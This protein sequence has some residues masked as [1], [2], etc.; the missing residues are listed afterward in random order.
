MQG[1]I[2]HEIRVNTE[3]LRRHFESSSTHCDEPSV[4]DLAHSLRLFADMNRSG[5]LQEAGGCAR[6]DVSLETVD[7]PPDVKSSIPEE[8]DY[9]LLHMSRKITVTPATPVPILS[10]SRGAFDNFNKSEFSFRANFGSRPSI[11]VGGL[12]LTFGQR[13]EDASQVSIS[14]GELSRRSL[15][16]W[17]W[18]D[19]PLIT[20]R[21]HDNEGARHCLQMSRVDVIR[22]VANHLGGSHPA[23]EAPRCRIDKALRVVL[24]YRQ[25]GL[26]LPFFALMEVASG[27]LEKLPS[28]Y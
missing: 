27:L 16:L 24:G 2:R 13:P 15:P 20:I 14:S 21:F 26:P 12:F 17:S 10:L 9:F 19:A 25:V 1:N 28:L 23:G 4:R 3:R 8:Q 7:L 11:T 22:R 18:L 6:A 5:Y